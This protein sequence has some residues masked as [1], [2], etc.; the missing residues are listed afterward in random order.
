MAIRFANVI[1]HIEVGGGC[2]GG[3]V[4]KRN[5]VEWDWHRCAQPYSFYHDFIKEYW[6]G[7]P[8]QETAAPI[9]R[10]CTL[11]RKMS[12]QSFVIENGFERTEIRDEVRHLEEA[13]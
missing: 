4:W 2:K 3:S 5:P 6:A 7:G 13:S 1:R 8:S 9:H 10:L 11:A 12:A